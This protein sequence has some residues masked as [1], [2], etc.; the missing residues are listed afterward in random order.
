MFLDLRESQALPDK[1]ELARRPEVGLTAEDMAR[2][3]G[4]YINGGLF[5][6]MPRMGKFELMAETG[7]RFWLIEEGWVFNFVAGDEG[8]VERIDFESDGLTM[9]SERTEE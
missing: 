3:L 4:A 6:D 7:S 1:I 2:Y 5:V 9:I 8:S